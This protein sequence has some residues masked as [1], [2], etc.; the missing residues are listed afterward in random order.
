MS[1]F[2]DAVVKAI[3]EIRKSIG[4]DKNRCFEQLYKMT[5]NHLRNVAVFYLDDK[6]L[7]DDV[8][9]ESF[10]RVIVYIDSANEDRDGY[11]WLCKIVQNVALSK[12]AAEKRA[13]FLEEEYRKNLE[14]RYLRDE[15]ADAEFNSI[16]SVLDEPDR[17]IAY[18]WFFLGETQEEIGRDH[19]VSKVAVC[20]RLKRICKKLK[21]YM[22][23]E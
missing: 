2:G 11:N 17:S 16:L 7:A 4:A 18:R 23:D 9:S 10:V 13:A 1:Y 19:G 3:K 22:D 8:V 5:A 12:N 20:K 21:N 15:F 14:L 6:S